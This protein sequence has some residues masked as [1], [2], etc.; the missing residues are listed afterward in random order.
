MEWQ[1]Q[2]PQESLMEVK[3]EELL[4]KAKLLDTKISILRLEQLAEMNRKKTMRNN[5]LGY[6]PLRYGV[7]GSQK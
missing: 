1:I 3:I 6:S 7:S 2:P 4:K 5:M